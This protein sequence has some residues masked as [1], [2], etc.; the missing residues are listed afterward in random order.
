MDDAARYLGVSRKFVQRLISSGELP[1]ARFGRAVRIKRST[2]E[3]LAE[4]AHQQPVGG[5]KPRPA[6]DDK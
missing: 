2:I 5:R 6:R 4:R 3:H 1:A